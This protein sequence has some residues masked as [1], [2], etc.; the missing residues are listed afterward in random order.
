VSEEIN[1]KM[2]KP[3]NSMTFICK[4]SQPH[5]KDFKENGANS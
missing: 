2:G 1:L 4:K 5:L 3:L